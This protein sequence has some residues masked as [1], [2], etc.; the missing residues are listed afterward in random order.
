VK[1]YGYSRGQFLAL[2]P[3]DLAAPGEADS[4]GQPDGVPR[5]SIHRRNGGTTIKA[6][7]IAHP[8]VFERRP[9]CCVLAEDVGE[10][11]RL[12]S[13]LRQAQK[14]EAVGQLAGGVA[15][16]FN[17][18]LT[19][20]SG[21]GAMA[22]NRIGAGPG[23]RELVEIGRASD[24]ATQLTQQL[25]AF[26]RQQVLEPE[27][28]DVNEVIAEV[29]PM[30]KRLIGEHVEIGVLTVRETPPV[31]ADRG[32]LEQVIVNLAVNA[33]DA[34]PEGGTLTI[35]TRT[36]RLDERY[37]AEHDGV[38]PGQ[39]SCLSVTDTGVG[40]DGDTRSRVFE[41]FFTTKEVG[42]GTGLGLVTVHGI[43]KQSGGH[44]EVYS[45]PGLGT[46]FKVYLPA[47]S[48]EPV[49]RAYSAPPRPDRLEGDET[50]LV[51][52]DDDLVRALIQTMLTENGYRVL[53]A[54][55][56][57]EALD[58][59][60]AHGDPIDVLVTDVVMP[61]MSGPELVKRLE[62]TRPDV[63]VVLLSGYSAETVGELH[64][65]DGSVFLQKPFDDVTLLQRIRALLDPETS[66]EMGGR[67]VQLP[68]APD[69]L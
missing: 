51:C 59:A 23:A 53:A 61:Q 6:Q 2:S 64:L 1:R 15:H 38:A 50:V 46:S 45:E 44:V 69:Q 58:L 68:G 13:Q 41:P 11:E 55:R 3:A 47:A 37:A 48:G 29:T 62:A 14:M 17:N 8:V 5:T 10:R 12:E 32:Q 65:P 42:D 7:T 56:P 39:Y 33:R 28:L 52:E 40:M 30:L 4:F 26:S 49:T 36:V 9:A 34:M 24:R 31:V 67:T 57:D 54:S 16:D 21:Y 27:V 25:L 43:V 19:V 20:I 35:E 22:R 60:T 66:S 63:K 18:L